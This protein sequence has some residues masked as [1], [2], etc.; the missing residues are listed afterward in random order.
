MA[1]QVLRKGRL[2]KKPKFGAY[3]RFMRVLAPFFLYRLPVSQ[4]AGSSSHERSTKAV[5]GGTLSRKALRYADERNYG[6]AMDAVVTALMER[7]TELW[8]GHGCSG[9]RTHGKM[10]GIMVWAWMER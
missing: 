4:V 2:K 10:N 9:T 7:W 1:E 5:C 3:V 6:L 8:F